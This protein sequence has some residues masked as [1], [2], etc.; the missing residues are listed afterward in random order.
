MRTAANP[1][2]F[3]GTAEENHMQQ[4]PR[5]TPAPTRATGQAGDIFGLFLSPNPAHHSLQTAANPT[6]FAGTLKE[7]AMQP[8]TAP[9]RDRLIKLPEAES[10]S[11][12]KKSTIYSKI[13]EGTFPRPVR[14]SSRAVAFSESAVLRWVQARIQAG[15][16]T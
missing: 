4:R 1:V 12:L 6:G 13:K 2:G 7:T 11:G 8:E 9:A 16:T 15:G 14:L 10:L 5:S 3:A